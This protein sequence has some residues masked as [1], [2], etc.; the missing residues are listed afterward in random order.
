MVSVREELWGEL[1]AFKRQEPWMVY[2]DF[3]CMLDF[4]D[5]LNGQQDGIQRIVAKLDRILGNQAWFKCIV[6]NEVEFRNSGLSDHAFAVV[7]L[8]K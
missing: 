1:H 3:N 5:R 8:M 2:G 6:G 4:D 7:P